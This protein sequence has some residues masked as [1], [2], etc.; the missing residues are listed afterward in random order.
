MT[1][2]RACWLVIIILVSC[3]RESFNEYPPLEKV[4]QVQQLSIL[5]MFIS[6]LYSPDSINNERMENL[7]KMYRIEYF[8]EVDKK[9]FFMISCQPSLL[10]DA[11][12]CYAG[13]M[14]V[15]NYDTVLNV[16]FEAEIPTY[17]TS[18]SVKVLF[19]KMVSD[20]MQMSNN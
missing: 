17:F 9:S 20:S 14:K 15:C 8:V 16:S 6:N 11:L 2:K 10:S 1:V 5:K 18:D 7:T 13:E 12:I 19:R 3:R 4:T